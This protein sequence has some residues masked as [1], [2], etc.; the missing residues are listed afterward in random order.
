MII[1]KFSYSK[2]LEFNKVQFNFI[3]LILFEHFLSILYIYS[4]KLQLFFSL[5][6]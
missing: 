3:Q 5:I 4:S 6:R 2:I 1:V